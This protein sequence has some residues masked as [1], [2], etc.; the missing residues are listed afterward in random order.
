MSGLKRS[1]EESSR[2]ADVP[3]LA[4]PTSPAASA[5]SS[6]RNI[7]ACHRC[8]QRKNRCDQLLPS[9]A[10]CDKAAVKCVGYDP[11]TKREIPRRYGRA[12]RGTAPG[13]LA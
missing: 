8:R 5:T 6:F 12:A 4:K 7:S 2:D 1:L 10:A 3:S 11:I 9:C 13:L